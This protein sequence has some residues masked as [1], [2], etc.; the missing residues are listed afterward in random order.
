[1]RVIVSDRNIDQE[2]ALMMKKITNVAVAIALM[3]IT[4]VSIAGNGPNGYPTD[5][6]RFI[7][8]FAPGGGTD[9]VARIVAQELSKRIGQTVIVENKAGASGIIAA[10]YVARAKPD[11]YT[12]LVGGSGP[13]VFNPITQDALPY[14]PKN[15]FEPITILGSYPIVLLANNK[16]PY[17]RWGSWWT[18]P[19]PIPAY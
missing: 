13:M 8:S 2:K 6:V 7:V 17:R 1:L 15:D 5:P 10:Q 16:Q 11:G 14:D 12:L 9:I 3:S 19:R 18:M 4:H